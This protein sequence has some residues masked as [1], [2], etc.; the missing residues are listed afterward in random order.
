[1]DVLLKAFRLKINRD[2]MAGQTHAFKG[3]LTEGPGARFNTTAYKYTVTLDLEG[4][5]AT[6]IIKVGR[7]VAKNRGLEQDG[8]TIMVGYDSRDDTVKLVVEGDE[9]G[10]TRRRGVGTDEINQARD[11]RRELIREIGQEM[12]LGFLTLQEQRQ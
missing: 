3:V 8:I 12:E 4:L 5:D 10:N 9:Y 7:R 1:M 6:K 2:K 11:A